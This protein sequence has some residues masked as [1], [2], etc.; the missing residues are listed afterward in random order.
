MDQHADEADNEHHAPA[1]LVDQ[2]INVGMEMTDIEEGEEELVVI[3]RGQ[4]K[5][6]GNEGDDLSLIHISC[7]RER[8]RP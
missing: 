3:L 7:G 4:E 1:L 8:R 6:A 5:Q 2:D